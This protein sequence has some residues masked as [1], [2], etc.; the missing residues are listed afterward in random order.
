MELFILII[1]LVILT[2][3]TVILIKNRISIFASTKNARRKVFVD[4]SALIDGRILAVA[5]TGFLADN[6]IVTRSVLHE[7][8][9]LADGKDSE[10][11]ARA[12]AGMDVVKELE[13]VVYCDVAIYEDELDRT[14]VDDRLIE[15]AK[16][17]PGSAICT[18]D[19]NLGKVAE[20][21]KIDI[22]NVN[23]LALV[24]QDSYKKGQKFTIKIVEKGSNRGQGV[25]HLDDGSMVVVDK[26]S[27]KI[28]ETVKV[29]VLRFVQNASGR[30][31]FT[32]LAKD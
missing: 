14:P 6:L 11:R 26:A 7:L 30:I 24:L 15:L 17:N 3:T 10:K 9:L 2:E 23:E 13:R 22:L 27:T 32:K 5:N 21:E 12:R 28:G 25:G 4:T 16:E 31:V 1:V 8:Q 18:T 20:A 19:F 29:E